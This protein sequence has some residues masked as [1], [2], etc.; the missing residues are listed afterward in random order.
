M[1]NLSFIAEL[2][3]WVDLYLDPVQSPKKFFFL[4]KHVKKHTNF[5]LVYLYFFI[6]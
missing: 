3:I 4:M 5:E 1:D 6:L 2:S